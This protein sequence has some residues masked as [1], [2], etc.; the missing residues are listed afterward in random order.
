MSYGERNNDDFFLF[1]GY[2]PPLNPKDDYVLFK[3]VN[4][5][6]DWYCSMYLAEVSTPGSF[7]TLFL[8][9]TF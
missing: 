8:P 1:Y 6:V 4:E 3:D 7:L 5:A 2:I 9:H